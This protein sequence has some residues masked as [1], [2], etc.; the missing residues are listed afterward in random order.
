[1]RAPHHIITSTLTLLFMLLWSGAATARTPREVYVQ[2][3]PEQARPEEEVQSTPDG[4]YQ[5]ESGTHW[6]RLPEGT[7]QFG[8][9]VIGGGAGAISLGVVG[10]IG[11]LIIGE[12]VIGDDLGGLVFGALG[13]GVV[14]LVAGS[15]MGVYTV[16]S[17]VDS[18][19]KLWA[20]ALGSVL[21][22]GLGVM[23]AI[24]VVEL[25][26]LL[27]LGGSALGGVLAYQISDREERGLIENVRI[28]ATP[29]QGGAYAQFGFSF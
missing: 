13:A 25:P 27:M 26:F 15:T 6:G 7:V 29:T 8:A 9:G 19:G 5:L 17:L 23:T 3:K 21:G 1:M 24:F 28:Q 12:L 14:G 11:G 10:A 2:E 20:T 18:D 4:P 16:G 22:A